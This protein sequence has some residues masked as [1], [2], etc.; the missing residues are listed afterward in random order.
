LLVLNFSDKYY[1]KLNQIK[2]II[3]GE[4]LNYKLHSRHFFDPPEF[5]TVLE[6][7]DSD[8]LLHFGYFRDDP[9]DYP[10]FVAYNEPILNSIIT[11]RGDNI[12][13]AIK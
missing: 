6:V 8:T 10:T 9:A 7:T 2:T 11:C 12:F 5:Q 4:K 1:F 3:A 13:C